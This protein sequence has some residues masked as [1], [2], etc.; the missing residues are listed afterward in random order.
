MAL[1]GERGDDISLHGLNKSQLLTDLGEYERVSRLLEQQDEVGPELDQLILRMAKIRARINAVILTWWSGDDPS[2]QPR[3]KRL[4]L[5]AEHMGH[6]LL[7]VAFHYPPEL[8]TTMRNYVNR[9]LAEDSGSRLPAAVA[10][11]EISA[12]T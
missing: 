9:S 12:A 11:Q 6:I 10:R 8:I 2:G 5:R 3:H 1:E 7:G 4:G